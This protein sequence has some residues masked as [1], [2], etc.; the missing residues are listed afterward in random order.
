MPGLFSAAGCHFEFSEKTIR[1]LAKILREELKNF[2]NDYG[3][4][5]LTTP[6]IIAINGKSNSTHPRRQT[7]QAD[8]RSVIEALVVGPM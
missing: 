5:R 3:H 4:L 1:P 2:T 7:A 8:E 6:M